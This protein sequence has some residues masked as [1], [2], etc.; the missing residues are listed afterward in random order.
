MKYAIISDIHG[1]L[2]ALN[3]VISKAKTESVHK[4]ICVGDIV[5]YNANPVECLEIIQSLDLVAVVQGNNDEYAGETFDLTGLNQ[6]AEK[7]MVWT[8]QQLA[9]SQ[10]EWLSQLK[11][12]E[13]NNEENI[14]VVHATLDSP[15]EWGY[16]YDIYHAEDNFSYQTTQICFCGHSHVPVLFRKGFSIRSNTFGVID[17]PGW[18]KLPEKSTEITVSVD[19]GCKYLV[20]PGSVGQPRNGDHRASFVIYDSAK[21][22]LRRICVEYDIAAAQNKI[23]QAGLPEILALRLGS[24]T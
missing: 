4:Y 11:L 13:V 3:A 15:A 8:R 12:K 14:T 2:E 18:K 16:I 22:T 23:I 1:N 9:V 20:N 21:R 10:R 5:G 17:F 24:G 19:F 6:L 7:S